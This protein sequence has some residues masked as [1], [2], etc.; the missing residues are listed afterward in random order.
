MKNK[1]YFL[2]VLL[3]IT[4]SACKKKDENVI[5][6]IDYSYFP[7]E[8][9]HWVIYEAD[10]LAI[11][12]FSGDTIKAKFQIKDLIESTMT[13]SEGRLTQ[14][15]EKYRRNNDSLPW[16]LI[17]VYTSN[18]NTNTAET[19]EDNTRIINLIFPV[20]LNESW[21][22]NNYIDAETGEFRYSEVDESVNLLGKNYPST[23]TVTQIDEENLIKREYS[24][25]KY[26]K[27]IG[28]VY[29]E[30]IKDSSNAQDLSLP[31]EQRITGGIRFKMIVK[32]YGKI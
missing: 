11:D 4:I 18:L 8:V 19:F 22:G 9:G 25:E 20:K 14:R 21:K 28:L 24:I 30:F 5:E 31:L 32:A 2:L 23:A 12:E 3:L 10:S 7:I 15:R 6:P 13:D 26:S 16:E 1:N 29:K 17:K 27:N